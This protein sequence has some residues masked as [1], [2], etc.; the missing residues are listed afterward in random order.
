MISKKSVLTLSCFSALMVA[1]CASNYATPKKLEDAKYWQRKNSSSA[2]YMRGP[3]AQ[4][5]LHKSISECVY[6]V[7]ELEKLGEIRRAVPSNYNSGNTEEQRTAAQE[8]L[9][10]WD[11]PERDGYL[12]AE[13][14]DFHDFETC[15]DVKGWERVQFLPHSDVD[16]ANEAY[17]DRYG[18]KKKKSYGDRENVTSLNPSAQNPPPYENTNE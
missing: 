18:R 12:Y 17:L 5:I 1:A 2:L 13:H 10:D 8:E 4:Q 16:L 6:E 15:M 9:D 11:S 3:K 14:I 7:N